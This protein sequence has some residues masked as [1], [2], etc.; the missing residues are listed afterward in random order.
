MQIADFAL[1]RYFARWE[2]HVKHV[3]CASDVEPMPLSELLATADEESRERWK[4]LRLGYTESQGNPVLRAEIARLYETVA[5][6]EIITFTGAE[7][8]IFLAMHALLAAGDHAV[9]MW[10]AYQSLYEVAR[11]VGAS[12]TL[13]PL[14]PRTWTVDPESLIAAIR[15]NT[16]VVVINFPHSPSGA[17]ARSEVITYL[18]SETEKR[19]ITLFSDEVYRFLELDE[20]ARLPTGVDLGRRTLSLGVLSKAFALAGLRIGWIAT[21]D[22]AL[23]DRMARWK[24]YTTICGSAPSEVLAIMALRAREVIVGRSRAIIAANLPLLDSFFARFPDRFCWVRPQAG[25]VAFPRLRSDVTGEIDRFCAELV[26]SE[27]VLLLPGS[28]FGHEGN[29]FRIGYGRADM[30]QAL[31][32]LEDYVARGQDERTP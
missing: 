21:H 18:T 16:R 3:L 28:H 13:V 6:E 31:E 8:G 29:H 12:V 25:S 11:S 32:R 27:G 23:R 20:T 14:D 7:E 22:A 2:F 4:T 26:E 24:D 9:V 17:L 30:P 15:P 1:E 5:P 10:P 19:G